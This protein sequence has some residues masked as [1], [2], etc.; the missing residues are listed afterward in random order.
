[1]FAVPHL[2]PKTQHDIHSV[3][4]PRPIARHGKQRGWLAAYT[5]VYRIEGDE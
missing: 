2:G 4:V 5:G 1:L 3:N